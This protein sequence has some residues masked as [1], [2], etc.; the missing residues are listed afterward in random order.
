MITYIIFTII[1]CFIYSLL[2]AIKDGDAQMLGLLMAMSDSMPA[3]EKEHAL[4]AAVRTGNL[5][6]VN[7]LLNA[8][9]NP[10]AT[11]SQGNTLV[12]V[13]AENGADKIMS[14]L[15]EKGCPVNKRNSTGS[16]AVHYSAKYGHTE[17]T[18]ELIKAGANL[19]YQDSGKNTPLLHAAK[20]CYYTAK[21]IRI[22]V[23]SK[24]CELDLQD[25]VQRTALHYC[26]H[27]ACGGDILLEAGADPNLQDR[28]GNTPLMMAA[29]EG[30]D[31]VIGSLMAFGANPDLMNCYKVKLL[32]YVTV[33]VSVNM[34]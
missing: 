32:P 3:K 4:F 25:D 20:N 33:H 22:L 15:I 6:L 29:T 9:V 8:K 11:D 31:H 1:V 12:K 5:D 10:K 30:L 13:A 16:A 24:K 28:E 14:L 2:D 7:I 18:R 26:C 27:K 17:C 19:N 21:V 34:Y 23:A